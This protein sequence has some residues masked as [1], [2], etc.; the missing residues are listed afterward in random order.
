MDVLRPGSAWFR[1]QE[2]GIFRKLRPCW[3]IIPVS[4][5]IPL[6]VFVTPHSI[7]LL[8]K[9]T[10]R[11]KSLEFDY[12]FCLCNFVSFFVPRFSYLWCSVIFRLFLSCLNPG[13]ILISGIIVGRYVWFYC[14]FTLVLSNLISY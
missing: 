12:L 3:S 5:G 2:M 10:M 1:Q 4:P 14:Y 7:I 6:L 11:Y 8:L 9:A 13:S